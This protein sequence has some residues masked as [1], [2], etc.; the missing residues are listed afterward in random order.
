MSQQE[1]AA[2]DQSNLDSESFDQSRPDS[3]TA[4]QSHLE[5]S[6]SDLSDHGLS[7]SEEAYVV[8]PEGVLLQH[9]SDETVL[10]HLPSGTYFGLDP[11]GTR[12]LDLA[13]ELANSNSVISALEAEYEAE[14]ATLE[15]DLEYLLKD[16]ADKGLIIRP[17]SA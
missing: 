1:H 8:V 11:I 3:Q 10:L 17:D 4:E 15:H 6:T 5:T 13:L 16:L 7:T 9:V 12:M 14:R 2:E